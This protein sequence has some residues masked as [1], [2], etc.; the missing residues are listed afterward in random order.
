MRAFREIRAGGRR[1]FLHSRLMCWVA[2]DRMI[3]LAEKRSLAG[4]AD[5][6]R[7]V[8]DAISEDIFMNFWS[9]DRKAFHARTQGRGRA[10]RGGATS[11]R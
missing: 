4:P 10:R 5:R 3:R 8:R 7:Q 2:F 11:C 6:W 9:E 1:E